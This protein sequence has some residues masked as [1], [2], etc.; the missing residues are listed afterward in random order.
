VSITFRISV[1]IIFIFL[2]S[3]TLFS[4]A[5]RQFQVPQ[6]AGLRIFDY[7]EVLEKATEDCQS[8]NSLEL[9]LAINGKS[10]DSSIRGRVRTAILKPSFLRLEGLT[11]YGSPSFVLI[12]NRSA[13]VLLLPRDR[14]A[15]VEA[16][17]ADLLQS[18]TGLYFD[19]ED[20]LGVLTGCLVSQ[21]QPKEARRY[22][23]NM[24]GIE[25]HNEAK[26][27]IESS[28]ESSLIVAGILRSISVQYSDYQLGL[29]RALHI[30]T[31]NAEQIPTELSATLSQLNVNV[32]ISEE[33]FSTIVPDGFS[34]MTLD[35]FHGLNGSME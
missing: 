20:F 31:T 9:L 6:G 32:D 1:K 16:T 14:R 33:V 2:I 11:P 23:G 19:Q 35:E 7:E 28:D 4:C 5:S 34:L 12:S 22:Q 29:P 21:P 13:A 18:I 17:T 26:L 15:I 25:L 24:I 8:V 27:F 3:L 30:Q 10:G